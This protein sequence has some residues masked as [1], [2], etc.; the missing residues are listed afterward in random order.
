MSLPNMLF[1]IGDRVRHMNHGEG[2]ITEDASNQYAE[3]Y[4]VKYTSGYIRE[5][6]APFLNL[7]Q[8]RELPMPQLVKSKAIAV[9]QF[10]SGYKD[11]HF[12]NHME[13]LE[14]KDNVVCHTV[15]GFV[16]GTVTGFKDASGLA[17]KNLVQKVDIAAH[18]ERLAQAKVAAQKQKDIDKIKAEMEKRRQKIQDVQVYALL[19]QTDPE[20]ATLLNTL[21]QLERGRLHDKVSF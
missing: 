1:N 12:K 19:A 8:R 14:V 18:N 17:S 15:N 20:M 5:H 10:P 11:Y 21:A 7:V 13:D 4:K 9:V 16:V 2:I 3:C 6:S